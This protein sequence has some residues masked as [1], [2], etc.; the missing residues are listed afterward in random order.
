MTFPLLPEQASLG[1][2]EVDNLML[3]LMAISV[4][5][6]SVTAGP[7]LF[8]CFRYRRENKVNRMRNDH[9][10]FKLEIAWAVIPAIIAMFLFGYSAAAYFRQRHPPAN[11]MEI[12]VVGKQ[13][14][15][16]LQHPEGKREINELHIPIGIPIK[17]LMTSEDVIHSFFIPAF[18]VKQDVL[19]GRYTTEWMVPTRQGSYHLFCAEYCGTDHSRMIGR[20]TVMSRADYQQWLTTGDQGESPVVTGA[21]LFRELGCSGCHA[22]SPVSTRRA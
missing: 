19:P 2:R 20:V 16:K 14:M 4:F 7:V 9:A 6:L 5:F 17:L 18:R 12:H 11:A 21:R 10:T 3:W 15:W 13:W 22:G 1:A 8:F